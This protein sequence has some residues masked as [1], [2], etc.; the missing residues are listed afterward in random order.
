MAVRQTQ[1]QMLKQKDHIQVLRYMIEIRKVMIG[2]IRL[3][4]QSKELAYSTLNYI[5]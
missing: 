2:E 5:K 1:L 4:Y 3:L